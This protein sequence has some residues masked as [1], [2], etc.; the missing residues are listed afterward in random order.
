MWQK[1]REQ[2][3]T[4]ADLFSYLEENRGRL[5]KQ[6]SMGSKKEYP[7]KKEVIFYLGDI[8]AVLTEKGFAFEVKNVI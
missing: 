1:D 8:R 4:W 5:L 7:D 6:M 2:L 3:G